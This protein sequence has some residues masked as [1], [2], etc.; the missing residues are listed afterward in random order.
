MD[1]NTML[2]PKPCEDKTCPHWERHIEMVVCSNDL[3]PKT[4]PPACI[5][6]PSTPAKIDSK[7]NQEVAQG[8]MSYVH[9]RKPH[10]IKI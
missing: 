2:C 1:A 4:C 8:Q 6:V 3:R 5:P 7:Y 10:T 9:K